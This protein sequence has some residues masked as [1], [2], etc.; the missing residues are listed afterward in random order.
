MKKFYFAKYKKNSID[1]KNLYELL[2]RI[3]VECVITTP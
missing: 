1:F 3:L 2:G